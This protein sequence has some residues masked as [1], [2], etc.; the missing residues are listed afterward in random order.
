[1]KKTLTAILCVILAA[2]LA[3][4]AFAVVPD[5]PTYKDS[6]GEDC[7]YDESVFWI[8]DF[9]EMLTPGAD[10]YFETNWGSDEITDEFFDYYTVTQ[11]IT[12]TDDKYST[13][14]V[15][16]MIT[17]AEFVKG[18]DGRYYYHIAIAPNKKITE[19]VDFAIAIFAKDKEYPDER[20][21]AIVEYTI[22]YDADEGYTDEDEYELPDGGEILEFDDFKNYTRCKVLFDEGGYISLKL[23]KQRTF[24]F[25]YND[26]VSLALKDANPGAE[27]SQMNFFAKPKFAES[28]LVKLYGDDAKYLYEMNDDGS[29]TLISDKNNDG[30]FGFNTQQLGTYV[31]SDKVLKNSN[32][33]SA[34]SVTGSTSSNPHNNPMT[35]AVA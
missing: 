22:G 24:N 25:C 23:G 35:G 28:C 6:D 9:D 12:S 27:I 2:A 32:V 18:T 7:Y 29:L 5:L 14:E 26:K 21:A 15:K 17:A 31:F 30:L 34:G 20:A 16:K 3:V 8:D 4:S 1:M 33:S 10:H 19:D 11:S 13:S